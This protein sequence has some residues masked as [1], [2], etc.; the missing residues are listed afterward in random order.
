MQQ[1]FTRLLELITILQYF[2][3]VCSISSTQ[4]PTDKSVFLNGNVEF[5][6]K[7]RNDEGYILVWLIKYNHIALEAY[8]DAELTTFL[9]NATARGLVIPTMVSRTGSNR[10]SNGFEQGVRT[11]SK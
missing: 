5:N 9:N 8:V 11:S 10:I 2:I 1:N 6:C 3:A 4:S 7:I